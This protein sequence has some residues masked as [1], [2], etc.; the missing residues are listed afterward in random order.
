MSVPKTVKIGILAS[1][2]SLMAL[3]SVAYAVTPGYRLVDP[4]NVLVIDTT[5]G[6]VLVEIYPELAPQ[7][8]ER[9]K[10]LTRQGFYNGLLFHRVIEGFMAQTGDPKGTGTGNSDLPNVPAEFT[11]RR[12][13]DFP[14]AVADTMRGS[15][16]GY[17]KAMPVQSQVNELMSITKDNKVQT[18]GRFCQ[19]TLGMARAGDVNS[20]NSQFFLMRGPNNMLERQYTAFGTTL[21]GLD[22]VRKLKIGEPPTDPDKM[23]KVRILADIPANERPNIEVMDTQG[24]EFKAL[25]DKT[26]KES[27]SQFSSCDLTVPVKITQAPQTAK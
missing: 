10:T 12:G 24:A 25:V 14:I 6:Q 26:L 9:M 22:V 17:V 1:L 4:E 21:S 13:T 2:V 20:A 8:V 7:H 18:W 11:V 27:R 5:K 19:G 23:T 15:L 3:A 16:M